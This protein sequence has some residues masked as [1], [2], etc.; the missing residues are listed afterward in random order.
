[1]SISNDPFQTAV[2]TAERSGHYYGQIS[3]GASFVVLIKGVGKATYIEGNHD[4]KDRRTEV[5]M[6]LSP[7][8]EMNMSNLVQRSMLSES[9]EWSRI[10]WPSLRD[11]CGLNQL[12]DLDNKYVKV[13]LVKNGRTW[14][15]KK[16]G[17][18]REGTTF[19]FLAVYS[20]KQACVDAYFADGGT[21]RSDSASDDGNPAG[22]VNMTPAAGII[23]PELETAK[24]FL[25]AL[26]KQAAGNKSAL[27]T[28]LNG[29][30]MIAKYFNVN[31]PEVVA[32]MAA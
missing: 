1:M 26:V 3:V 18:L 5:S 17:E 21:D 11:G 19:K 32:L 24:A 6:A 22:A 16:T 13:E 28:M 25:P 20:N 7:L 14:N 27:E 9:A 8:D 15:D 2:E 29:M 4:L 30:P 10:V 23:N 12:R 31:S